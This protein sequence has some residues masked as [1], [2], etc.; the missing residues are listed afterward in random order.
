[1]PRI[2][3]GSDMESCRKGQEGNIP[4]YW[5]LYSFAVLE[6]PVHHVILVVI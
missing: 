2:L 5:P 3:A 6:V 4:D 1:M